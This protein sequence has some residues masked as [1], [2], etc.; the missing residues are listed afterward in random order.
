MKNAKNFLFILCLSLFSQTIFGQD[1]AW[2]LTKQ[3]DGVRMYTKTVDCDLPNEGLYARYTLIKVE[4]TNDKPVSVSW[5]NHKYY[6]GECL[7]C[8]GEEN[9][10]RSFELEPGEVLEGECSIATEGHLKAFVRWTRL[11]NNRMLTRLEIDGL[12]VHPLY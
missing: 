10:T 12:E 11:K 5:A 6:N 8:S 7:T 4:N 3:Q 1:T 2:D 9:R